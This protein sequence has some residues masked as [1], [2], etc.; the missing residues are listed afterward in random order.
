[1][2]QNKPG[3]AA[4][5]FSEALRLKPDA[6]AA[7]CD[8][9]LALAR[10]DKSKEAVFHYREALRLKS[11]YPDALN[12]LAWIL[13]T[14]PNPE[15]RAGQEAVRLAEQACEL[16]HHQ[17]AAMMTT[18]AAAY[19]ETGRFSEAVVAAEKG[20]DLAQAAG[21]KEIATKAGELLEL[22]RDSRPFRKTL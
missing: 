11:D 21:Q 8:L 1:L 19:A 2:E 14:D 17:L 15:L 3:A 5:R 7:H 4:E 10:Q 22:F 6:P 12:G 9:A 13:A 20:R 18:L 16:T